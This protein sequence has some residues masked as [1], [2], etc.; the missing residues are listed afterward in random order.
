M[1]SLSITMQPRQF[2]P[3]EIRAHVLAYMQVRHGQKAAY[4][5]KHGIVRHWMDRWRATFTDGDLDSG[6]VPR[7]SGYMTHEELS[8]ITRLKRQ[9]AERDARISALENEV[10]KTEKVAEALGKAIDVMHS[11]GVEPDKADDD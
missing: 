8:E 7:K 11:H 2:T 9:L 3:D 1:S 4:L 10:S 5:E 6:L